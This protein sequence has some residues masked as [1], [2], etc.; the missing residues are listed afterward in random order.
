M[1]NDTKNIKNV[2]DLRVNQCKNS[3]C[4]YY[5]CYCSWWCPLF[6]GVTADLH[7]TKSFL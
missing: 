5:C 7:S 2:I 6:V 3:V 1:F 4:S